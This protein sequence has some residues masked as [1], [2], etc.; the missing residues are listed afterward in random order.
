[1]ATEAGKQKDKF[2]VKM[3]YLR[4]LS[5]AYLREK[6]KSDPLLV[7]NRRWAQKGKNDLRCRTVCLNRGWKK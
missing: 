4:Q 7:L 1:M 3:V 6:E 5:V 2:K